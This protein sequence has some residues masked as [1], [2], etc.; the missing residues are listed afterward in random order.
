MQKKDI[1]PLVTASTTSFFFLLFFLIF[2]SLGWIPEEQSMN[3]IGQVS[4]WCERVYS[5]IFREPVNT[6]SNLGFICI[7]L[8]IFY[9]LQKDGHKTN[10]QSHFIGIN[11]ISILYASTVIFLGPGSMLMH[12]TNTAW[13]EWADNLSMIMYILIPWLYN[14]KCMAQWS[15]KKFLI[16]YFSIVT[17]YGVARGAVGWDLGIGLDLFGLSIGL[18]MISEF[19]YQF[20]SQL[21]RWLSGLIGFFVA[22]IFGIMPWDIFY[23]INHYWWVILFW[24]PALFASHQPIKRR[25]YWPWYILGIALYMLAFLFWLKGK[26]GDTWCNPDSILQMHGAWHLLTALSTLCFFYFLRTERVKQS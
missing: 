22:A 13:G 3:E 16:I 26:L 23:N 8:F 10:D 14:V 9:T 6:I 25:T 4:K 19:L 1:T 17:A 7:G 15:T 5:G 11:S 18:W 24:L 21:N 12:G 2:G 20:W